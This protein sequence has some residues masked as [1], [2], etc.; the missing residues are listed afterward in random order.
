MPLET[1]IVR[2]KSR[3]G[4]IVWALFT[5]ILAFATI[6]PLAWMI[7][8]AL[9]VPDEVYDMT[10]I[11][12]HP[13]LVNFAYVFTKLPFVRYMLN[14][15]F[16]AGSI[17]VLA[18]LLH[19]MAAYA[20][21]CLR[22]PGRDVIFM[23]IFSTFLISLPVIIVP[24][25]ILARQFGMLNNYAG[26]IIPPIFNAFGIFLLR[27]FYIGIPP[28]L[29]E[30]AII[31]GA[32]YW[33]IYWNIILPLSRP[34]LAAMSVFFFLANWNSFL[35]PLTITTNQ[36][37]WVVQVAIASFHDQYSGSWNF[38]MAASTVVALPTLILFFIFQR[39][40]IESIKTSGLK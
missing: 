10:L 34:I 33:G 3:L 30:A 18:L 14:T 32:S 17:T 13:T 19:S 6:C 16:I 38:I 2:E 15:F 7:S 4:G 11:P 40:L 28:E 5:G 35:W 1:P 27:Q 26:L 29:Q 23:A 21:S 36:N 20:F 39:Q 12:A 9:K 37:L 24:L 22:F 8:T 31:D 25:F